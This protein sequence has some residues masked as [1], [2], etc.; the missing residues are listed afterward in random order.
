VPERA[1]KV[2]AYIGIGSNVDPIENIPRAIE[3]LARE[4]DILA[5]STFYRTEALGRP[6][7]PEFLNGVCRIATSLEPRPLKFGV[8]RSIE[9][10]LGRVR[11][12]DKY[13][14]RPIDLD[15]LLYGEAILEEDDLR[16]P[17]PE[18]RT[19]PFVAVPLLELAPDAA[20]PD[21]GERIADLSA[22]QKRDTLRADCVF[23]RG[24][25]KRLGHEPEPR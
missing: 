25:R 6:G 24:I 4:T 18:I 10:A 2:I 22:A 20:L 9:R 13:A 19:R 23:T 17:D 7:Q 21:T 16:I 14:P 3:I 1:S 15:I 12:E 11:S 8:L 5:V